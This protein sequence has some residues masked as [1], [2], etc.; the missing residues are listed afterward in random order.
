ML[1]KRGPVSWLLAV[2]AVAF[3]TI[4]QLLLSEARGYDSPAY[5]EVVFSIIPQW[6][7]GL[8]F[9]A[10]GSTM[11]TVGILDHTGHIKTRGNTFVWVVVF[12]ASLSA[13]WAYWLTI[14][15]WQGH[16]GPS[17]AISWVLVA[18]AVMISARV[19]EV[20]DV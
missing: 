1:K 11:L 14:G 2:Y 9:L 6:V 10:Q 7:W 8:S 4:G 3:F 17:S 20:R 15:W 12:T 19:P 18:A 5:T 16:T 13:A